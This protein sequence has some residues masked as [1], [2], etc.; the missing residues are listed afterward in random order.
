[1]VSDD[2]LLQLCSD[3][4]GIAHLGQLRKD[5]VTPYI[6]HPGRVAYFAYTL[7]SLDTFSVCAAWLH[8]VM[9]DCCVVKPG[10]RD[11]PYLIRNHEGV[12]KDIRTFLLSNYEIKKEEGKK[13]LELAEAMT[14]SKDNSVP[15][16]IISKICGKVIFLSVNL[17]KNLIS[18]SL[19][20]V[21]SSN[22]PI[23]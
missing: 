8:D 15:T 17:Y 14:M 23:L 6:T 13:I 16:G 3:Y 12:Y 18:L 20:L 19:Y 22:L 7:G 2:K 4:A 10:D 1:M 9:E 5:G 11:Y 21:G